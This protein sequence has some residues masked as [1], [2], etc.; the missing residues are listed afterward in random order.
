M[1]AIEVKFWTLGIKF[2]YVVEKALGP[3]SPKVATGFAV[4]KC[5]TLF[6][7]GNLKENALK[8]ETFF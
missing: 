4:A 3:P 6:C 5:L 8:N 1:L 7:S 2:T